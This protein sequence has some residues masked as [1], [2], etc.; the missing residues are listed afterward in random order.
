VAQGAIGPEETRHREGAHPASQPERSEG[1]MLGTPL[2]R[3]RPWLRTSDSLAARVLVPEDQN[4]HDQT[5]AHQNPE[6]V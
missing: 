2:A 3:L 5:A 6:H 4:R 1:P